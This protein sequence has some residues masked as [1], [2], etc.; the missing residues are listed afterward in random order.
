MKK[1]YSDH[2]NHPMS[3]I[4]DESYKQYIN[5]FCVTCAGTWLISVTHGTDRSIP[6]DHLVYTRRSPDLGQTW[7]E[8]VCPYVPQQAEGQDKGLEMGQL[9]PVRIP[10]G[11]DGFIE[12]VYQFHIVRNIQDGARFGR[13]VFTYSDDDGQ[14]WRGPTGANSAYEMSPPLYELVPH[15]W[16]WH[17][18]APPI[19]MSNGEFILPINVSTDPQRLNDIRSE[20]VFMI[21]RNIG[22][23]TDPARIGFDFAPE[24][25][26][27]V[28]AELDSH[29]GQSLAQ[30]AQVVELSDRRLMTVM[31]TGNGCMFYAVSADYGR[32]WTEAKPLRDREDGAILP[33]PN[34]PCPFTRLS[35]GRYALLYCNNNGS[36]D[37]GKTPYDHTRNRHP[38]YIAVGRETGAGDGQPISF[39]PPR[40]LCS[41]DGFRPHLKRDLAYGFFLEDHGEFYHFYNAGWEAIQVN[42]VDPALLE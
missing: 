4:D 10:D 9:Y 32:T 39:G 40:L 17:L 16:G 26:H 21:S 25:P 20:V 27:G 35:D 14:S 11:S 3:V 23:E 34:A 19:R 33:H 1:T 29:P 7:E 15:H 6:K 2:A 18:M 37:G 41:I 38:I 22:S 5:S 36:F 8:R 28:R 24:P 30:E 31:R 12:R 42:R 13:L